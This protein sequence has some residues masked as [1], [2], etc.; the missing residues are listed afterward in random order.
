MNHRAEGEEIHSAGLAGDCYTVEPPVCHTLIA[1]LR[2][3][4]VRTILSHG[5]VVTVLQYDW[6]NRYKIK[7]GG[8][9][10]PHITVLK[11]SLFHFFFD[12]L[13]LSF[14][15]SCGKENIAKNVT[16]WKRHLQKQ[17]LFHSRQREL[18]LFSQKRRLQEDLLTVFQYLKE[19]Y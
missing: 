15:Y 8:H 12:F 17:I 1:K 10:L 3:Q 9:T 4:T 7:V 5:W 14:R 19:A 18:G 16:F 2:T 13:L 11:H 6:P